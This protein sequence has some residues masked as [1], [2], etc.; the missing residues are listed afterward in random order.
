VAGTKTTRARSSGGPSSPIE[1]WY[2]STD[3][4]PAEQWFIKAYDPT[5]DAQR[6]FA[7]ADFLGDSMAAPTGVTLD[8]GFKAIVAHA[9]NLGYQLVSDEQATTLGASL[10]VGNGLV[11]H[12]TIEALGR[13]QQY[14][15]LPSKHP[16]E[17]ADM[18]RE[19]ARNLQAAEALLAT[20]HLRIAEL[21]AML[22]ER[23]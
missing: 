2:G 23:S 8:E 6:D 9:A 16:V 11:V 20:A 5:K 7:L 21:S 4:H 10:T 18:K 13:V 3:W 19:L 1:L 17:N 12:G 15:L 14:L 22:V